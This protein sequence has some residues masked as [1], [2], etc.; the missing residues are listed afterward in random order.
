[1]EAKEKLLGVLIEIFPTSIN[2]NE[3]EN[4][5]VLGEFIVFIE[6]VNSV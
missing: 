2:K 3:V 4:S 5:I 6:P 1:M